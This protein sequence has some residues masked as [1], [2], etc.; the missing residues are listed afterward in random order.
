M[1]CKGNNFAQFF[2]H[3]T[4]GRNWKYIVLAINAPTGTKVSVGDAILTI[5]SM[6]MESKVRARVSGVVTV[7]VNV[8]DVVN[9]GVVIAEIK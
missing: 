5:E 9:A 7:K 2:I 4:Y 8:N 6:K 1:P 3:S